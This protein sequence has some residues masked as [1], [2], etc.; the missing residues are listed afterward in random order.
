MSLFLTNIAHFVRGKEIT[1]SQA[2]YMILLKDEIPYPI[3]SESLLQLAVKKLVVNGKIGRRMYSSRK[4]EIKGSILPKFESEVSEKVVNR[5]C[6]VICNTTEEGNIKLPNGETMQETVDKYLGGE[7]FIADFFW[8]FLFLFPSEGT[9]NMRWEKHFIGDFYDGIPLRSRSK[10][11]GEMFKTMAKTKDMGAFLL[12]AYRY[13]QSNIRGNKAFI[14]TPI[15]FF[16]VYDEFYSTA[17][18]D[19][20]TT[21]NV[22]SLFKTKKGGESSS[23]VIAV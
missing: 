18:Y 2:L 7:A 4:F 5:L 9:P 22:N 10:S 3:K 12:G 19:I 21:K 16:K 20:K 15:K 1:E 13:I 11:L 17:L 6:K 14:T 8:T 23:K